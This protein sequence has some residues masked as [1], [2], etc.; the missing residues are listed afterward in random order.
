MFEWILDWT[1]SSHWLEFV[2]AVGQL[3]DGVLVAGG[4]VAN[5]F[6]SSHHSLPWIQAKCASSAS[7]KDNISH[8]FFGSFDEFLMPQDD[9]TAML[10]NYQNPNAYRFCH[11]WNV[12][13]GHNIWH[14]DCNCTLG[15]WLQYHL[16][17][18]FE[19]LHLMYVLKLC[20]R[21]IIWGFELKL[22]SEVLN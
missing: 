17:N 22:E 12:L 4:V 5:I 6:E 15:A 10:P 1:Y 8:G 18:C 2:V 16:M 14:V 11:T 13:I 7:P 20:I 21:V 3:W 9:Y 19:F